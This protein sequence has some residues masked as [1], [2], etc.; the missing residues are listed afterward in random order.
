LTITSE[1][2]LSQPFVLNCVQ[3]VQRSLPDIAL[4]AHDDVPQDLIN[5]VAAKLVDAAI[6]F[7]P[8][9]RP[10]LESRPTH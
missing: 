5:Q 9:H 3:W 6:I 7:A 1:V 2:T 8:Q 4:R 10:R